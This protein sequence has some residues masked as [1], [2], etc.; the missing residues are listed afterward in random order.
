[1][2]DGELLNDRRAQRCAD[3]AGRPAAD[4]AGQFGQVIGEVLDR[5]GKRRRTGRLANTAVV[6]DGAAIGAIEVRRLESL[7]VAAHG[8]TPADPDDIGT[9]TGLLVVNP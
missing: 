9:G 3:E 2:I 5:P 4:A 6:E 7:P 1:M 8:A